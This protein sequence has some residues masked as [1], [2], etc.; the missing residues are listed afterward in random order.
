MLKL[1]NFSSEM[2]QRISK[3]PSVDLLSEC[4]F[5]AIN[6]KNCEHCRLSIDLFGEKKAQE[7][8]TAGNYEANN[9]R[10]TCIFVALVVE[11]AEANINKR[12]QKVRK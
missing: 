10:F 5:G 2:K 3:Y 1:E 8:R 7:E 6:S 9:R 12:K 4:P 11:Q